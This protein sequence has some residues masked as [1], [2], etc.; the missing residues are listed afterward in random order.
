MDM[1][2]GASSAAGGAAPG[3][4][5]RTGAPLEDS[6]GRPPPPPA[7]GGSSPAASQIRLTDRR[8]IER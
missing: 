6:G 1:P 2:A 4:Q 3:T 5:D 8:I 7:A